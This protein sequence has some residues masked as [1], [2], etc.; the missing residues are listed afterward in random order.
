MECRQYLDAFRIALKTGFNKYLSIN[1]QNKVVG[2]SDAISGK[3]QW[4][5]VFEDV[6]DVESCV[7]KL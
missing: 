5:P 1:R 3:E 7:L 6:S 2:V 4:E